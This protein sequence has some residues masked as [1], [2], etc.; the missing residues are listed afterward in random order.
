MLKVNAQGFFTGWFVTQ[1]LFLGRSR[2]LTLGPNGLYSDPAEM[3][4]QMNT[5]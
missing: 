2:I 3:G 1:G 5:V 4:I